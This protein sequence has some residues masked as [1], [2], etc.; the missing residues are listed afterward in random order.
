VID[1]PVQN[2]VKKNYP[3]GFSGQ[4]TD[5]G[6]ALRRPTSEGTDVAKYRVL[7]K[8]FIGNRIVEAGEIVDVSSF[9]DGRKG[10][11][12]TNLEALDARRSRPRL[13]KLPTRLRATD[14]DDLT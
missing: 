9:T 2:G 6:R 3:S 13:R 11:A 4:V 5:S 1:V 8:S 12:S 14:A 10:C 7:E